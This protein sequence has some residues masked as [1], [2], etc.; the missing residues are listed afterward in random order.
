MAQH[1]ILGKSINDYMRAINEST[2]DSVTFA[3][4]FSLKPYA[5]RP[6]DTEIGNFFVPLL[7]PLKTSG[8]FLKNLRASREQAKHFVGS[9]ELLG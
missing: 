7:L 9:F 6:E 4:T 2:V 3:T 8:D 1:A 5:E